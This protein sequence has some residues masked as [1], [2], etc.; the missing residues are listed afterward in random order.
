MQGQGSVIPPPPPVTAGRYG[1]Y[2]PIDGFIAEVGLSPVMTN[3]WNAFRNFIPIAILGYLIVTIINTIVGYIPFIGPIISIL[4]GGAMIGGE[5]ILTLN[6]LYNRNPQ[7][8]DVFFGFQQYGKWLVAYLLWLLVIIAGAIPA[9]IGGVI[10]GVSAGIMGAGASFTGSI[11]AA[12]PAVIALGSLLILATF[13]LIAFLTVRWMFVFYLVAEDYNPIDAFR[14][15]AEITEG[16]RLQLFGISFVIGLIMMSGVIAC[17]IG[18]LFTA[19]LGMCMMGA[20]YLAAR[21]QR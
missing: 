16:R 12:G 20:L 21:N 19:P 17:G 13:V 1:A 5:I 2:T 6:I 9:I 14:R 10:I 15:S 11:S 8:G 4:I 3:G 7:I 18:V